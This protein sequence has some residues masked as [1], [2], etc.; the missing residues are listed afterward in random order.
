MRMINVILNEDEQ[1]RLH[2]RI[3]TLLIPLSKAGI[4]SVPTEKMA[5][6]LGDIGFSVSVD[7]LVDHLQSRK[8]KFVD[9]VTTGTITFSTPTDVTDMSADIEDQKSRNASRKALDNIK[10]RAK[11]RRALAKDAK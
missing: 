8:P 5:E 2:T 9:N 10:A 6:L 3:M 4:N 1:N 11:E 7:S